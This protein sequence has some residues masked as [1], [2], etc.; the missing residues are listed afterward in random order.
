MAT[1][2]GLIFIAI[3]A[4]I[5]FCICTIP[6]CGAGFWILGVLFF[7]IIFSVTVALVIKHLAIK[8]IEKIKDMFR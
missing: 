5:I 1:D 7:L 2:R 3:I 4:T 8:L 6:L